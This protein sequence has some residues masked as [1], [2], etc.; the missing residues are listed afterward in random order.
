[1]YRLRCVKRLHDLDEILRVVDDILLLDA[2]AEEELL[3]LLG[4]PL[5]PER[6]IEIDLDQL[7]TVPRYAH[8]AAPS[9][10]G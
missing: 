4:Q 8:D 5:E 9:K 3:H 10:V 6:I 7:M 1:L 2:L